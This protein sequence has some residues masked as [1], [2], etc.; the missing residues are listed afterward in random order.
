MNTHLSLPTTTMDQSEN[1]LK[2]KPGVITLYT[3]QELACWAHLFTKRAT[4]R[5]TETREGLEAQAKDIRDA[6]NYLSVLIERVGKDTAARFMAEI[7]DLL[8]IPE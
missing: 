5:N 6:S 8:S 3:D 2:Y 1:E 7:S 4:H